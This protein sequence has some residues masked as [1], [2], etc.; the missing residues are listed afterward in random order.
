MSHMELL[1]ESTR[2]EPRLHRLLGHISIYE[3]TSRWC[4]EDNNRVV[5]L[6][7]EKEKV[8]VNGRLEKRSDRNESSAKNAASVHRIRKLPKL[9]AKIQ[10]QQ[11]QHQLVTVTAKEV[12][13]CSEESDSCEE[14]ELSDSCE[15]S[16]LSDSSDESH[17]DCI[18]S[19]NQSLVNEHMRF[20]LKAK[21]LNDGTKYGK[22]LS[23]SKATK[24]EQND[25]QKTWIQQPRVLTKSESELEFHSLWQ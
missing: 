5:D 16:E 25:D 20:S 17:A 13:E 10:N 11:Q 9:Q 6:N 18:W 22:E 14:S 1:C 3:S 21:S 12:G 15:E 8:E 2:P 4:H 23:R 7:D 24:S 19:D